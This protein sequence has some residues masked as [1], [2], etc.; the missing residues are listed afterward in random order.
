MIVATD[1]FEEAISNLAE[2][3][4]WCVDVETNGVD[5]YSFHQIYH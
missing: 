2:Y 4:T 5:P 1:N 3:D